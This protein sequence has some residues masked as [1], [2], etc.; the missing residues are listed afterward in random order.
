MIH[1]HRGQLVDCLKMLQIEKMMG[2]FLTR[3]VEHDQTLLMRKATRFIYC[4]PFG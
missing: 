4:P 2:Y 3:I 1:S